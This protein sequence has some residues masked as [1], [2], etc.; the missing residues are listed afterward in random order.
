[1]A[2]DSQCTIRSAILSV[3]SRIQRTAAQPGKTELPTADFSNALNAVGENFVDLL[4]NEER[5]GLW[6]LDEDGSFHECIVSRPGARFPRN[7]S[8]GVSHEWSWFP[9]E[10]NRLADPMTGPDHVISVNVPSLNVTCS[11]C[12]EQKLRFG[13][14]G[15]AYAGASTYLKHL[16]HRLGY[17]RPATK[18][19]H[20]ES[21][22]NGLLEAAK[23]VLC[24]TRKDGTLA[25]S[26]SVPQVCMVSTGLAP[27]TV[28]VT[29]RS[30]SARVECEYVGFLAPTINRSELES[31]SPA[32]RVIQRAKVSL[33]IGLDSLLECCTA[34]EVEKA[35]STS[36]SRLTE[37]V[38][39]PTWRNA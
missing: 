7:F 15:D 3:L 6:W 39:N 2:N 31:G 14:P 28:V 9:A 22:C 32:V 29:D 30:G 25:Y 38:C 10:A 4:L 23:A 5:R 35:W 17:P 8:R 16:L 26:G 18:E 1:M 20:L 21:Y 13:T 36:V 19:F 24:R 12:L 33:W 11:V 34:E 27:K 37:D